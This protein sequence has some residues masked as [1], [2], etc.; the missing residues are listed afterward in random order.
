MSMVRSKR[1]NAMSMPCAMAAVMAPIAAAP[2]PPS[3]M[4]AE[5][6]ARPPPAP[7]KA[8]SMPPAVPGEN[9]PP[10]AFWAGP[11]PGI[12]MGAPGA[13]GD[14][15]APWLPRSCRNSSLTFFKFMAHAS[16]DV[17]I[18]LKEAS[19]E[20]RTLRMASN[21]VRKSLRP[22]MSNLSDACT[23]PVTPCLPKICFWNQ[24][25]R[26]RGWKFMPPEMSTSP[27]RPPAPMSLMVFSQRCLLVSVTDQ[28]GPELPLTAREPADLGQRPPAVRPRDEVVLDVQDGDV[29]S[30]EGRPT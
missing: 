3:P 7:L 13:V 4:A 1:L 15:S 11:T 6:P 5:M 16:G 20:S 26:P 22:G 2:P 25:W 24:V 19:R 27:P 28:V 30:I 29:G 12:G 14:P 8:L 23:E 9:P 18:F 17:E 21:S 10:G